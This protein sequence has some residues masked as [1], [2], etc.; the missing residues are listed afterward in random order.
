MRQI[1]V[2]GIGV[3]LAAGVWLSGASGVRACVNWCEE[4][5]CIDDDP[6][7]GACTEWMHF[8]CDEPF[9]QTCP[10]GTYS[11]NR[12]SDGFCCPVGEGN[13]CEC[14]TRADGT[15][16]VCGSGST[17]GV[18]TDCPSGTVR[19]NTLISSECVP[20]Q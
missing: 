9:A 13:T 1:L 7:T 6:E 11:C 10:A 20:M 14:G 3:V 18:A 17:C 4:P 2:M 8:C 5:V 19:T 12:A 16:R 15:C